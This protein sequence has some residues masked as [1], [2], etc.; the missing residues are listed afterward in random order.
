MTTPIS[1]RHSFYTASEGNNTNYSTIEFD[2]KPNVFESE[3]T[4]ETETETMQ[5][6]DAENEKEKEQRVEEFLDHL[7]TLLNEAQ[8]QASG[9]SKSSKVLK[10]MPFKNDFSNEST[11]NN[12]DSG[13]S[14]LDHTTS[15]TILDVLGF[16]QEIKKTKPRPQQSLRQKKSKKDTQMEMNETKE[17][18]ESETKPETKLET[19]PEAEPEAEPETEPG[20]EPGA[21]SETKPE[22]E[23]KVEPGAKSGIAHDRVSSASTEGEEVANYIGTTPDSLQTTNNDSNTESNPQTNLTFVREEK[24]ATSNAIQTFNDQSNALL[25]DT[26]N[27][28]ANLRE[29]NARLM[30]ENARL[31]N[32]TS[33]NNN[34]CQE[35]QQITNELQKKWDDSRLV[36][37]ESHVVLSESR[38]EWGQ[39]IKAHAQEVELRRRYQA[40]WKEVSNHLQTQYKDDMVLRQ[41]M[42]IMAQVESHGV[43]SASPSPSMT[44]TGN[45]GYSVSNTTSVNT[46]MSDTSVQSF[47]KAASHDEAATRKS[48]C[49]VASIWQGCKWS[50]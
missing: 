23:P 9:E 37:A 7:Q 36:L 10:D 35:L 17:Q 45:S 11:A 1:N 2:N 39:T 30:A 41:I 3:K 5:T 38:E 42:A 25:K 33:T 50:A 27:E 26:K 14:I 18:A 34:L 12:G 49:N 4:A 16:A 40:A 32:E 46:S 6:T 19:K 15:D 22:A 28:I 13:V 47:S 43:D 21:E 20:A 48:V 31:S 8:S 29:E 24:E 44:S